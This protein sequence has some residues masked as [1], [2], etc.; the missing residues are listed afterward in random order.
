MLIRMHIVRIVTSYVGVVLLC[1]T[2]VYGPFLHEHPAG[3][4]GGSAVIH[5]H[6]PEP[7][8]APTPGQTS[9]GFHHS[10]AKAVWLDGFT[11][12]TPDSLQLA[13]IVTATFGTPDSQPTQTEAVSVEMPRAH[14]PPSIDPSIPRSP[15]A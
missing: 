7:E 11:T 6:I 2:T 1:F 5:A 12:T 14:S 13:A 15:P 8:Q 9:I 10:H 4:L 3:E